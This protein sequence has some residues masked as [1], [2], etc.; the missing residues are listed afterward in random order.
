VFDNE[1]YKENLR[2]L[3]LYKPHKS[4]DRTKVAKNVLT[5]HRRCLY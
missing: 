2:R 5:L 1:K 4:L 3:Q